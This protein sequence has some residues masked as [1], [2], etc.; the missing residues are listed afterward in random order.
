M[1]KVANLTAV[2][3]YNYTLQLI[4]VEGYSPHLSLY[5]FCK[6]DPDCYYNHDLMMIPISFSRY[7]PS[8]ICF[9]V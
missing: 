3:Q 5:S 6:I 2:Q 1:A 4:Q 8:T 9:P 7:Y